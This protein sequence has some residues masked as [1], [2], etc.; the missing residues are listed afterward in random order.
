MRQVLGRMTSLLSK[1]FAVRPN[2]TVLLSTTPEINAT[3]CLSYGAGPCPPDMPANIRD[4]NEALPSAV[5]APMVAAGRRV[6]LR[7]VNADAQW[8]EADFWTWGIHRSE[9]GFAKMAASFL[10]NILAHVTPP[11]QPSTPTRPA[12]HDIFSQS[13][14]FF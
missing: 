7:D 1:L 14:G 2:A 4:L 3:K 6:Y 13:M 8:V 9:G 10:K 5:V 12:D 11:P